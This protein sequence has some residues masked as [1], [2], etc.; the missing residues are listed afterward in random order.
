MNKYKLN[1]RVVINRCSINKSMMI[2]TVTQTPLASGGM[3][4]IKIDTLI[5]QPRGQDRLLGQTVLRFEV[6]LIK[7]PESL[8]NWD[9]HTDNLTKVFEEVLQ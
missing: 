6:E 5:N 2:G 4:N 3:Y 9:Q 1:D 7:C 8:L